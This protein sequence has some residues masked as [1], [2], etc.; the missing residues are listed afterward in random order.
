MSQPFDTDLQYYPYAAVRLGMDDIE[1][2]CINALH[3]MHDA[4]LLL[5]WIRDAGIPADVVHAAIETLCPEGSLH[6]SNIYEDIQHG[7][8]LPTGLP[9]G[10]QARRRLS[11]DAARSLLFSHWESRLRLYEEALRLA[12]PTADLELSDHGLALYGHMVRGYLSRGCIHAARFDAV[13]ATLQ[14]SWIGGTAIADAAILELERLALV[15]REEEGV[16][17]TDPSYRL[18]YAARARLLA[19][20]RLAETFWAGSSFAELRQQEIADVL[21]HSESPEAFA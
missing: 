7:A 14:L 8:V 12:L 16:G 2:L 19:H 4:P 13:G 21:A 9:S 3:R 6:W 11:F 18:T 20:F 5:A 15:R 10:R 1:R 17:E